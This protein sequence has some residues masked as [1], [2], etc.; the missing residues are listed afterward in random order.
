MNYRRINI[1]QGS[2]EWHKFRSDKVGASDVPSILEV[3]NSYNTRTELLTQKI[4]G[5]QEKVSSFVQS[6][7]DAGKEWEPKV[8]DAV[9]EHLGA[10]VFPAVV[11]STI[12]EQFI[13]S[14]DGLSADGKL[15]VEIKSTSSSKLWKS[16]ESG[17]VPEHYQIQMDWQAYILGIDQVLLAVVHTKSGEIRTIEYDVNKKNQKKMVGEVEL[18]LSDMET[19]MAPFQN[20]ETDEMAYIARSKAVVAEYQ[21]LIDQE[22]EKIKQMAERILTVNQAERIA[23]NGVE[24]KWQNKQGNIDWESIPQVKALSKEYKDKF[25]KKSSRFVKI[26]T[27]KENNQIELKESKNE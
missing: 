4:T 5:V 3:K 12:N 17:I 11:Q 6:M 22:E 8:L 19:G 7:M 13:A 25:R 18:F 2:D 23:G 27:I 16:I 9:K 21:K 10:E 1:E 24:I 26:T 15:A 14:L 20:I